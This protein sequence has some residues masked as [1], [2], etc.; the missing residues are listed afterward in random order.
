MIMLLLVSYHL[1]GLGGGDGGVG[2]LVDKTRSCGRI[3]KVDSD[4]CDSMDSELSSRG[5]IRAELEE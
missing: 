4:T 2:L 3:L 5:S 1:S